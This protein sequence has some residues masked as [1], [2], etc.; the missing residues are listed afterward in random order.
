MSYRIIILI[1]LYSINYMNRNL[2]ERVRHILNDKRQLFSR[3]VFRTSRTSMKERFRKNRKRV[4]AVGY[5]CQKINH[6][7][8]T[9]LCSVICLCFLSFS[10]LQNLVHQSFSD[11]KVLELFVTTVSCWKP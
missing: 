3:G 11:E 4:T 8:A 1:P 6:R 9:G 2:F 5:L 7:Y 10:V